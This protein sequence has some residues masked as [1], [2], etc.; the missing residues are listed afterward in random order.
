MKFN[1]VVIFI[2]DTIKDI[3]FCKIPPNLSNADSFKMLSAA[4]QLPI[5]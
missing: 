1:S 4:Q 5:E 3:G 2:E